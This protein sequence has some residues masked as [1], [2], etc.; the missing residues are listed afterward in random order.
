MGSIPVLEGLLQDLVGKKFTK[1]VILDYYYTSGKKPEDFLIGME[2]EK[3]G[4]YRK[5]GETVPYFGDKGFLKI[6]EK[7]NHELGWNI[8]DKSN[9]AIFAMSRNGTHL[10]LESDG[11]IELSGKTHKNIHDLA[12]EFR[13][14]QNEI[15]EISS[16]FGV[17][18]LGIGFHP[19]SSNKDLEM[20]P[21]TRIRISTDYL[22][23][24][25]KQGE[26][27]SQRTA[28]VQAAVDYKDEA[29]AMRKF[30][31][32]NR[33][34]PALMAMYA[35]SPLMLGKKSNY[36]SYR[37]YCTL[38]TDND[39]FGSFP[40]FF[41]KGF[42]F[43]KWVEFCLDVPII[44][45]LRKGE[46]LPIKSL[47]FRQFMKTGFRGYRAG[48]EDW[49]MHISFMYTDVRVK[50]YL[51]YRACDSVPPHLVP[52]LPALLKGLLYNEQSLAAAE[53]L[54]KDWEFKDIKKLKQEVVKTALQTPFRDKKI[55]DWAKQVLEIATDGL[56]KQAV[57]DVDGRDESIYLQPLKEIIMVR[58][59]SPAAYALERWEGEW[60]G[61]ISKLTD[62]CAY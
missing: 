5:T 45:I 26:S 20:I 36:L 13:L 15:N 23:H 37:G 40:D 22:K 57:L 54:F 12:R 60:N 43:E 8:D 59:I 32:L 24:K 14:H 50:N 38:N 28:S 51:E 7:L 33:M 31:L 49:L 62:W 27:W 41:T 61:E 30:Q 39:R 35:N 42:N 16:I 25:G 2:V 19:F 10:T 17:T 56:K 34:T 21:K 47:T 11:R 18:W 46:W 3:I 55:V 52:S 6:L 4:V 48:M 58:G 9:D 1:K 53:E 44:T 29:D